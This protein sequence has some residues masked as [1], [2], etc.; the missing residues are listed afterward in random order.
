MMVMLNEVGGS[1]YRL[2]YIKEEG[3]KIAV[4][5]VK[6][7]GKPQAD[8]TEKIDRFLEYFTIGPQN[9]DPAGVVWKLEHILDVR[10]TRFKD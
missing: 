10:D 1:L 5:T 3:R 8:P 9:L 4:E 6:E 2:K 7:I